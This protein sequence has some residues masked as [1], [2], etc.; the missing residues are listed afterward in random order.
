MNLALFTF[1]FNLIHH[2]ATADDGKRNADAIARFHTTQDDP[3][4]KVV[5]GRGWSEIGYHFLA[6]RVGNGYEIVAGRP[7]TRP[8][9]HEKKANRTHIGI[10]VVGNF[11]SE[12]PPEEQL[13][14]VADLCVQLIGDWPAMRDEQCIVGHK[15]FKPTACP[16]EMFPLADLR[17]MVAERLSE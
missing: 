13:S 7:L 9:S 10:C 14:V 11:S 8:G 1:S 6:E 5:E 17:Q 2:S 12:P 16:G 4:T 3:K 15:A